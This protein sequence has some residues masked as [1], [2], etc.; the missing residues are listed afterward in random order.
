MQGV[1]QK[2]R[3][4]P[5]ARN[6]V[7]QIRT[8]SGSIQEMD[9]EIKACIERISTI[10]RESRANSPWTDLQNKLRAA[11]D[12]LKELNT[13]KKGYYDQLEM[14]KEKV[15]ALR[16]ASSNEKNTINFK[17]SDDIDSK[18]EQLQM[19]LITDTVNLKD[20]RKIAADLLA[21]RTV[22]SRLGDI[23]DKMNQIRTTDALIKECKAKIAELAQLVAEKVL[24]RDSLRAEIDKISLQEKTKSPEAMKLEARISAL[25]AKKQELILQNNE[26]WE[27][28]RAL[29]DEYAKFEKLL[30]EQQK[31][32]ERKQVIW[33]N[34][35]GLK[36]KKDALQTE[37]AVFDP[38]IFDSLYYTVSQMKNA[39]VI[40]VDINLV[41][42]LLKHGIKVPGNHAEVVQALE[43]IKEKREGSV[44]GFKA[45]SS[46]VSADVLAIDAEIAA[47]NAKLSELPPTDYE[48]LK[49]GSRP[50]RRGN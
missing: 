49:K 14:H 9:D 19:K 8:T 41:S 36:A 48:I 29:E 46:E 45:R 21:L 3:S 1:E 18:I 42:A 34:I 23:E 25:K 7:L 17:S 32:E 31:L 12:I 6:I 11:N 44:P 20:E 47:E 5:G 24:T 2:K 26:K 15:K 50:A 33:K 40:N 16:E 38:K 13:E 35:T 30:E 39:K 43:M 22:K 4:V 10:N 27:A 37:V 28:V